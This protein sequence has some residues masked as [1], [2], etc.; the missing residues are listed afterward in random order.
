VDVHVTKE[1][2]MSTKEILERL[3][4]CKA[5]LVW[6][7]E[8]PDP[9]EAWASART[10]WKDWLLY[11][12]GHPL[13]SEYDAKRATLWAKLEAKR[14]TLLAEYDAKRAM[15][16]AKYVA[17]REQLWDEYDAKRDSLRWAELEALVNAVDRGEDKWRRKR[18]CRG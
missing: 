6:A 2:K 18:S 12:I 5:S 17:K 1:D 10:E 3:G 9:A 13:W 11:R 8:H 16:W 7:E 15:V 14:A 4:A